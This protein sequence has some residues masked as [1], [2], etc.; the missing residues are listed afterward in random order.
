[1]ANPAH[2]RV[3]FG[4]F[5]AFCAKEPELE[6]AATAAFQV[7]VDALASIH[8][9]RTNRRDDLDQLAHFIWAMVH[10]VAMLGIDGQLGPDPAAADTLIRFGI[11]RMHTAIV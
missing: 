1:M 9:H 2:Y 8:A 3:M 7:L 5:R 4:G 11:S 10:G 6:S